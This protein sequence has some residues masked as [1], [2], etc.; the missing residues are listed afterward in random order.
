MAGSRL[1]HLIARHEHCVDHRREVG[2]VLSATR[3][4]AWIVD[5]RRLVKGVVRSCVTCRLERKEALQQRMGE[6]G[7][8]TLTRILPL[9]QVALDLMGPLH[10]LHPFKPT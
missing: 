4:R 6:R 2:T 9:Q 8:D 10:M 5:G 7:E 1:A 3:R